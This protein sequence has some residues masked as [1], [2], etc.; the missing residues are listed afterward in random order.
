M[1][2]P[3]LWAAGSLFAAHRAQ[4]PR[5]PLLATGMQM[6][7]G[8]IILGAMAAATGEP[9]RI[10][11]PAISAESLAALAYLTVIG[12]LVAFTAYGWL[13]RVAPLPLIAT[14]AYVNPIVAVILGALIVSEEVTPRT[15]VAGAV[16]VFAVALIITARSRMSAPRQREV[17]G[18]AGE[19]SAEPRPTAAGAVARG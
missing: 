1:L 19:A 12:S 15:V 8:G 4:L 18:P 16:I 13:L 7:A 14:Y 10:H 11:L 3:I 5:R 17:P 9:A 6:V 2:A